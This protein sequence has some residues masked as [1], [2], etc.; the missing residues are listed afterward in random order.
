[1]LVAAGVPFA[2]LLGLLLLYMLP[3]YIRTWQRGWTTP[4]LTRTQSTLPLVAPSPSHTGLIAS[5][6][7]AQSQAAEFQTQ[8]QT[9]T[10]Q[11]QTQAEVEED[12]DS[13]SPVP[14]VLRRAELLLGRSLDQGELVCSNERRTFFDCKHVFFSSAS[15]AIRF[16]WRRANAHVFVSGACSSSF[17]SWFTRPYL[18]PFC[19]TL[20]VVKSRVRGISMQT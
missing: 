17:F 13:L 8:T 11:T 6:H 9:Q 10:Q 4:T 19:A 12:S 1:M 18:P 2:L 5:H 15:I 20:C 16:L 3:K 7:R 14:S